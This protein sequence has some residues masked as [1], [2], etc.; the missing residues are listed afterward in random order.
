[1]PQDAAAAQDLVYLFSS[2]IHAALDHHHRSGFVSALY[3]HRLMRE[4]QV[5]Y[6]LIALCHDR[7]WVINIPHILVNI[8]L[9]AGIGITPNTFE[10]VDL[11]AAD[12]QIVK[13]YYDPWWLNSSSV[14]GCTRWSVRNALDVFKAQTSQTTHS[15]TAEF[16]TWAE[17]MINELL[18]WVAQGHKDKVEELENIF[19]NLDIKQ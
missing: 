16:V 1:M 17:T 19:K 10:M 18:E 14:P 5:S 13:E 15:M 11:E 6:R 8:G 9:V 2:R 12:I 3:M 4:L 7:G